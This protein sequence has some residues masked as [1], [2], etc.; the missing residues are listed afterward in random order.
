MDPGASREVQR[1]LAARRRAP[2]RHRPSPR[3]RGAAGAAPGLAGRSPRRPP[4]RSAARHA[5]RGIDFVRK[6][7]LSRCA[8]DRPSPGGRRLSAP[9]F[10]TRRDLEARSGLFK[11]AETAPP[12]AEVRAQVTPRRR[13]VW[14]GDESRRPRRSLCVLLSAGLAPRR[15]SGGRDQRAAAAG[16]TGA[17]S[18]AGRCERL[19][20]AVSRRTRRGWSGPYPAI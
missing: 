19:G 16:P 9:G 7:S 12:A 3:R 6:A 10:D 20:S 18:R 1:G 15:R 8:S 17:R 14:P 5:T 13:R 4:R 11:K 2:A